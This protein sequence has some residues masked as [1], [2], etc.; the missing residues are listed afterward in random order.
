ML[1]MIAE[2]FFDRTS[3]KGKIMKKSKHIFM[4]LLAALLLIDVADAA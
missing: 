1:R 2:G 4:L 3:Q